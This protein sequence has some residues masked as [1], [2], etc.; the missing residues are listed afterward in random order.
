MHQKR[1]LDE[2]RTI[3]TL[4]TKCS[5]SKCPGGLNSK[6]VTRMENIVQLSNISNFGM[7]INGLE[8]NM[9]IPCRGKVELS[10][11][12]SKKKVKGTV[13][14]CKGTVQLHLDEKR[15]SIR[16]G[17]FIN[18]DWKKGNGFDLPNMFGYKF[19][20]LGRM[21]M[22]IGVVHGNGKHFCSSVWS[23]KGAVLYDGMYHPKGTTLPRGSEWHDAYCPILLWA[24]DSTLLQAKESPTISAG[25]NIRYLQQKSPEVFKLL[26]CCV[27]NKRIRHSRNAI[28]IKKVEY[29]KMGRY[30]AVRC[31]H[32]ACRNAVGSHS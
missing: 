5:S 32:I 7:L 21:F 25:I 24:I 31:F 14:S 8:G 27:C 1:L 20:R 9:S 22:I 3:Q 4:T 12:C 17:I 2:F 13:E 10:V 16:D 30:E 23:E 26:R 29:C 6:Q 15:S 18:I 11:D 28:L 19:K